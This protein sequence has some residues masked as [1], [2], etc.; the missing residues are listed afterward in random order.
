MR[1]F[2]A[3]AVRWLAALPLAAALAACGAS[4]GPPG[5]ED[6]RAAL[7]A[8][9]LANPTAQNN[10]YYR[11]LRDYTGDR[12]PLRDPGQLAGLLDSAHR[13]ATPPGTTATTASAGRPFCRRRTGSRSRTGRTG[14]MPAFFDPT[15][16]GI[17]KSAGRR[18][19]LHQERHSCRSIC[20]R[21]VA[22][23]PPSPFF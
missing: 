19:N 5:A 22:V 8:A 18:I 13:Q 10:A 2:T 9:V 20:G 11:M 17:T 6:A 15:V 1:L 12:A 16:A 7:K 3:R 14:T 4:A 21:S 23:R